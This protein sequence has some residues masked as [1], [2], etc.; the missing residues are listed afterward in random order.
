MFKTLSAIFSP[1]PSAPKIDY[2]REYWALRGAWN[3]LVAQINAKGGRSFLDGESN[4][5]SPEEIE[6]LIR[7]CHPDKHGGSELANKMTAKLLALRK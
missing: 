5:F 6:G 3:T 4:Q 2:R 7:L 1:T